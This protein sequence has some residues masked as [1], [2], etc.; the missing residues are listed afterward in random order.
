MV[1]ALVASSVVMLFRGGAAL[2]TLPGTPASTNASD[3]LDAD[4][5]ANKNDLFP[6]T[7]AAEP[8]KNAGI[9][10]IACPSGKTIVLPREGILLERGQ[11]RILWCPNAKV[12]TST[13]FSTFAYL[14]GEHSVSNSD[15]RA[16]GRQT[17][18][19]NLVQSGREKKLCDAM[20]FSFTVMRNPWDRVRSAY[21]DKINR[22]IFVP[23]HTHATFQQFLHA[24]SKSDPV[25]MNAHWKP[26]SQRCVTAGPNRF[27][28]SKVYK[29]ERNFEESIAEAFAHLDIP[30]VRT[31][32]MMEKLGRQNVGKEDHTIE[33]RVK[34]YKDPD[35]RKIIEEIYHD[36]I[37]VGGYEF[38]L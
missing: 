20:P 28:Y 16:D 18:I 4:M 3:H 21:L 14:N 32:A 6:F 1:C 37:E 12:G 23:N 9:V 24:I 26:V 31:R 33:A 22:V 30:K 34:A 35:A 38:K 19:H 5:F 8:S 25:S 13:I 36:D 29:M 10:N 11:K 15:A 2:S 27:S 17:S 7:T